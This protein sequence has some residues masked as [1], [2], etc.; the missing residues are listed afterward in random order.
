M[1]T[2]NVRDFRRF[3]ALRVSPSS[4]IVRDPMS[5]KPSASGRQ[6]VFKEIGVPNREEH[7]VK[8]QLVFTS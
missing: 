6:K 3:D 7:V 8:A 4:R 5:K 2:I 1:L